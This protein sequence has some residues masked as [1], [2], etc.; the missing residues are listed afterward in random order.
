MEPAHASRP[1]YRATDADTIVVGAGPAGTITAL[2]LARLGRDVLVLDQ[3]PMPRPKP[4]GDCLSAAATTLLRRIG[5]L[6]RVLDAGAHRLQGWRIV[7]PSGLACTGR[8]GQTPSLA[9]ERQVLDAVLLDAAIEA[10]ARFRRARVRA[11]EHDVHGRATGVVARDGAR[12]ITL[13]APLIVGADGLRSITA[14][15]L[16]RV[17]R[18]PLLRKVSLTTHYEAPD[19]GDGFGEMYVLEGGCLG[20]APVGRGRWNLTLVVGA[21]GAA[22]LGGDGP[23]AFFREWLERVPALSDRANGA[24]LEPFL[25]SG[26]FDW[27][28]RSPA[29]PGAVLVGDAAGYYDPFTGQGVYHAMASAEMLAR[30]LGPAIGRAGQDRAARRYARHQRRLTRPSRRFQR[31]VE[32]GLSRAGRADRLLAR[33]AA[34]PEVMDRVVAVTG[35]LRRP[36]SLLSPRMVTSFLLPATPG[37]P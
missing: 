5:L 18:R 19:P 3:D 11:L 7:A 34:A 33:L 12:S 32:L 2:L 35:D 30:E 6:Q 13:H 4:C 29:V 24:E 9:L 37:A 15:R 8:F 21:E 27:P 17:R 26:P 10:G 25:A 14:R 16:D 31:L 22:G 1:T 28:G 36:L 20:H 23:A